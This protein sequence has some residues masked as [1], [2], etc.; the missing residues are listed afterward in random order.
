MNSFDFT[1]AW[2]QSL[3][4][5]LLNS[6]WQAS[7]ITMVLLV[8]LKFTPGRSASFRHGMAVVALG[9]V[10][11]SSVITFLFIQNDTAGNSNWLT[12]DYPAATPATP[13]EILVVSVDLSSAASTIVGWLKLH[14]H[15]IVQCWMAGFI[16][17]ALRLA[18]GFWYVHRLRHQSL[19]R[20]DH[21]ADRLQQLARQLSIDRYIAL[22]EAPVDAPLV[23]GYLKPVIIFPLGLLSGLTT[24]QVEAIFVHELSHIKRHDFLISLAQS[25]AETIFFFNPFVW[26]ISSVVNKER[27]HCCDDLV[28][29]SGSSPLV[30][31]RTLAQLEEVRLAPPLV[32][33]LGGSKNQL[34]NRIKRIMEKTAVKESGKARFL[35]F[36]LILLG[37]VFA[38]WLSIGHQ[39]PESNLADEPEQTVATDTTKEKS[40]EK[41]S[42]YE[43][44]V[45]TRWDENGQPTEEVVE[46]ITGEDPDW[47]DEDWLAMPAPMVFP[48]F[49]VL[50]GV[51]ESPAVADFPDF[52]SGTGFFFAPP[53]IHFSIDSLPDRSFHR[54][55]EDEWAAFEEDF[56]T[57]FKEQFKDFYNKNEEELE[58]LM[59]EARRSYELNKTYSSDLLANNLE[60]M[61]RGLALLQPSLHE[62]EKSIPDMERAQR[63]LER[64]QREMEKSQLDMQRFEKEMAHWKNDMA[65]H[66][67][68]MKVW[69]EKSKV[70][71]KELKDMLIQDGYLEKNETLN[72]LNFNDDGDVT[73]NGKKVKE[74]DRAKYKDLHRKHFKNGSHIRIEE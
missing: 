38:S 65:R 1:A 48:D 71:E 20:V 30:Y 70:F 58:K 16:V 57:K 34:L 33:G 56:K 53:D 24:E 2:M 25:I 27:E 37:L 14:L 26:V 31:A 49:P 54:L 19:Y 18:L 15:G 39:E 17:F 10:L 29:S 66:E 47:D 62:L 73:V 23:I 13:R 67:R 59:D 21:R 28:L 45:I 4:W 35:P 32:F 36:V 72:E 63:D 46:I 52:P 44:R 51:P 5:T 41:A 61:T 7:A 55:N 64:S 60:Q 8:I 42:S 22:A 9:L 69:E 3:G 74:K 43:K 12:N 68:E 6:I 40:T 50:P 11:V